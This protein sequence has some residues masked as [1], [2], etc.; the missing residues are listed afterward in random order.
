MLL[1]PEGPWDII[2]SV[3][4]NESEIHVWLNQF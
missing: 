1:N 3:F 2:D 4:E